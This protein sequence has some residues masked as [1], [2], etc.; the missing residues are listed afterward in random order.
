MSFLYFSNKYYFKKPDDFIGLF[1]FITNKHTL[2]PWTLY[3]TEPQYLDTNC[4]L[5]D[6]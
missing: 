5:S 6:I 2:F 4:G 3:N 1:D